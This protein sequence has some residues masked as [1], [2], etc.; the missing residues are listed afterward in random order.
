[1][2]KLS[3]IFLLSITLFVK[4]VYSAGTPSGTVINNTAK[5]IYNLGD[6]KG[7]ITQATASFVVDNKVNVVITPRG[8][9]TVM[10]GDKDRAI[11][12]TITNTGNTPQRYELVAG[13]L[14]GPSL[15]NVRIYLDKD[16][17]G[18]LTAGDIPYVDPSTFGDILP[19]QGI[20]VLLVADVP[21]NLPEGQTSLYY[22]KAITVDAGTT[23]R[24]VET[25]G[26][27]TAGVDVVFADASGPKDEVR[28]GSHSAAGR[29]SL[30]SAVVNIKKS[31]E[32]IS[33]PTGEGKPY[34][35]AILKYTLKVK[36]TGEAEAKDV[37]IKDPILS[38]LGYIPGSLKLNNT[39]LTDADDQDSGKFENNTIIVKLGNLTKDSNEQVITFEV[40]VK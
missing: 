35:D 3:L 30:I 13:L 40:K 19:D 1:M 34:K 16:G 22:L 21:D 12:F 36:V 6:K 39:N 11:A 23:T 33:D 38:G 25:K 9:A 14:D 31:V 20:N 29:F 27:N 32:V 26:A 15:T 37:V 28:D 4:N 2:K 8:D 18:T 24:T 7:L 17:S 5:L 10:P